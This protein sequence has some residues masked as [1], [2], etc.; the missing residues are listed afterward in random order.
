MGGS[1]DR[2]KLS[3][4]LDGEL[5]EAQAASLRRHVDDCDDCRHELDAMSQLVRGLSS[6]PNV[7]GED[8]WS[9][10]VNRLAAEP[11]R[12]LFAQVLPWWRRRFIV[13]SLAVVVALLS[14]GGGL[15]RWHKGR[16][17]SDDAVIAEA[18]SEFRAADA[19]YRRAVDE[20]RTVAE[21]QRDAWRPPKRAE[22]DAAQS[23]LEA[24][25]ARCHGVAA[26][27]PAD[28]EAEELLFAAY[29]K[30]IRFYEDQM[31]RE[32]R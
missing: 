3:L 32:L 11:P 1:C 23:Q 4:L 13:P 10:L 16:G 22:Y 14:A 18:E 17:L 27:R 29:R 5:P 9:V 20:L 30:E 2:T 19:H 31:M 7:E 8:N 12:P 25:V 24:A 21:R 26:E 6:L 28:P 15:L